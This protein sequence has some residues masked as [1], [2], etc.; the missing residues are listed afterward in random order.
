MAL[1]SV[2]MAFTVPRLS[3][4]ALLVVGNGVGST[5][6]Q[7]H[8]N[9]TATGTHLYAFR[10]KTLALLVEVTMIAYVVNTATLPVNVPGMIEKG[11]TSANPALHR[12]IVAYSKLV[13]VLMKI[14]GRLVAAWRHVL[15][16]AHVQVTVSAG[17]YKRS[18]VS[19]ISV[20][21]QKVAP[22]GVIV[23]LTGTAVLRVG[24]MSHA[25]R[26]S[27]VKKAFAKTFQKKKFRCKVKLRGLKPNQN[28]VVPRLTV[29][30][31]H[32]GAFG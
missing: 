4:N 9:E 21:R 15:P 7:K 16:M 2:R 14:R 32:R 22:M 30:R 19:L 28:A 24:M 26:E 23:T 5:L 18:G 25:Q 13:L 6:A 1:A 31:R 12:K 8:L 17:K 27:S 10:M 20:C 3:V 29:R 11:V